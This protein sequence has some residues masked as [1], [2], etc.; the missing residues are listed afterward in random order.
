[1]RN[2]QHQYNND[3]AQLGARKQRTVF[4]INQGYNDDL[5]KDIVEN[6]DKY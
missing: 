6:Q 2:I 5:L 1:M 3:L 4:L